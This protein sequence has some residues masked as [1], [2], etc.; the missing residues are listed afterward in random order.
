[1]KENLEARL[2]ALEARN[3]E[4]HKEV[5][6]KLEVAFELINKQTQLISD[7]RADI[8]RGSGAIKAVFIM[9]AALGMIY[10]WIKLI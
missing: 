3:E 10:T 2:A 9:G 5:A 7:L 4:Q 8:A 6:N 1:M